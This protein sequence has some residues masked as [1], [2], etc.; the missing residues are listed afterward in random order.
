MQV[1][2]VLYSLVL[3]R[4][5]SSKTV[6]N[7]G[8]AKGTVQPVASDSKDGKATGGKDKATAAAASQAVIT[9]SFV[10]SLPPEK[11]QELLDSAAVSDG[12]ED[13]TGG[14]EAASSEDGKTDASSES[15]DV[16]DAKDAKESK[17]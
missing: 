8:F 15:T 11:L 9:S 5:Y 13:G 17:A 6:P 3:V 4:S 10:L 1:A 12:A 2:Q 7:A 14:A 16:K